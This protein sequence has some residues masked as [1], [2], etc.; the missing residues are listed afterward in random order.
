ME[1]ETTTQLAAQ[2][3]QLTEQLDKLTCQM[4]TTTNQLKG[5]RH[6]SQ[7]R[8]PGRF[9]NRR[10]SFLQT[11]QENGICY[12]HQ[13]FGDKS[14]KC[15]SPCKWVR[16]DCIGRSLS[17][18]S[19]AG[20]LP[21]RLLFISD[22]KTGCRYLV[23]TGAEVSRCHSTNC[24]WPEA[25]TGIRTMSCQWLPHPNIWNTI[26]YTGLGP[27]TSLQIN[28]HS[29]R[30]PDAYTWGWFPPRVLTASEP[31]TGMPLRCYNLTAKQRYYLSYCVT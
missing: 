12:Y 23:N 4:T 6:Q 20:H 15:Q 30:H 9:S 13:K 26:H 10:W 16:K 1:E 21:S 14:Y 28:I 8:S 2:V 11:E 3:A 24:C 31:E 5:Y 22:R 29:S 25:Q 18:T 19:A 27:S 7:S 17:T